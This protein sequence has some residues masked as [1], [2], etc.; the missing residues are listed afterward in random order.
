[1]R[2][3]NLLPRPRWEDPALPEPIGQGPGDAGAVC[4]PATRE[5]ATEDT[6][7]HASQ[8]SAPSL[9]LPTRA[10][11]Y[12]DPGR[13]QL[14]WRLGNAAG[15][16]APASQG[17]SRGG[18]REEW[19]RGARAGPGTTGVE[20]RNG[21]WPM[22]CGPRKCPLGGTTRQWELSGRWDEVGLRVRSRV[23][24]LGALFC[25]SEPRFPL[26]GLRR[27]LLRNSGQ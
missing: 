22:I 2:K 7:G 5:H 10:S 12:L 1:M 25:F 11:G 6:E 26:L 17:T 21:W 27:D 16:A 23:R 20:W 24:G 14:T 13:S 3:Q 18:E 4:P 15:G 9:G 8:P 19:M